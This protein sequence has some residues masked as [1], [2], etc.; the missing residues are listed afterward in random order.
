MNK[1]LILFILFISTNS[2]AQTG[3]PLRD[4]LDSIFYNI[5]KSQ[6]PSGYLQEYGAEF[7]ALHRYNGMPTD[8]NVIN[9]LDLFRFIYA[10]SAF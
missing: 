1:I 5:D 3:D 9:N 6:I 8:S 2:N 7:T 4:K 10:L